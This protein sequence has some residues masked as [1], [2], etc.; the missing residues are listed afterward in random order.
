[1]KQRFGDEEKVIAYGSQR[2]SKAQTNYSTTRRE[3]LAVVIFVEKF[4]PCL[5]G[6][7]FIIRTDHSA[8]RWIMNFRNPTGIVA[9]W[10]ET[11]ARFQFSVEH[12]PGAEHVLADALSRPVTSLTGNVR[13]S[14]SDLSRH[15]V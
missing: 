5:L 1:M 9:R 15:F 8:L 6:R 2:F 7:N 14:L 12:R 4:A 11:L 13:L 10:L 3:L